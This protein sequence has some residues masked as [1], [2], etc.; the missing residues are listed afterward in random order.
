[1]LHCPGCG[2]GRGLHRLLHGDIVGLLNANLLVA[3]LLPIPAYYGSGALLR[4]SVGKGL[5]RPNMRINLGWLVL[6]MVLVFWL[7]RNLPWFPFTWLAPV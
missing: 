2:A 3:V 5:P 6:G 7:L 4:A 1:G